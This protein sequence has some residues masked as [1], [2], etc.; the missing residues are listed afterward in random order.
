VESPL[1]RVAGGLKLLLRAGMAGARDRHKK[2][3]Q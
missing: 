1:A 2:E 3:F